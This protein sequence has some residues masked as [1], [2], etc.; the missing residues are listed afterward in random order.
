M[1]CLEP[2]YDLKIPF[3]TPGIGAQSTIVSD[4]ETAGLIYEFSKLTEGCGDRGVAHFVS[5]ENRK[6]KAVNNIYWYPFEN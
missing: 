6:W 3:L 4:I 1:T 5:K 2:Q